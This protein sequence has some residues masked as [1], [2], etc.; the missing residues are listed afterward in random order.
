MSYSLLRETTFQNEAGAISNVLVVRRAGEVSTVKM[1]NVGES[2]IL[3]GYAFMGDEP[4][5]VW[6]DVAYGHEIKN[7]GTMQIWKWDKDNPF[8]FYKTGGRIGVL[9]GE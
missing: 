8:F 5:E 2:L 3:A 1:V 4:S 7:S 9:A 6:A